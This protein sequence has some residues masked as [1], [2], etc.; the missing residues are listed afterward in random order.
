MN[1]IVSIII[2]G[3]LFVG[4]LSGC[5]NQKAISLVNTLVFD[6]GDFQSIRLDYDMEDI[7]VVEGESGKVTLKEYMN[8]DKK[9]YYAKT[10]NL[11]GEL[12]I[13]EGKRPRRSGFEAYIELYIPPDYNGSLSLHSTSGTVESQ[14]SL[15]LS[16]EICV[17]TTSGIINVSDIKAASV[18]VTTTSGTVDGKELITPTLKIVSTNG[19]LSFARV[20]SDLI[21]IET[22]N[23]NT[24]ISNAS[25]TVKYQSKGGRL[26]MADMKGSGS[27]NA[28]GE[29]TIEVTFSDVTGDISAY[30]KNG[31]ITVILPAVLDFKFSATTKEGSI[32]T[33]FDDQLLI[34]DYISAGSIGLSP[35]VSIGLETRNGDISVSR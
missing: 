28:S 14:I 21:Q 11:N 2:T 16:G 4:V 18:S 19:N 35:E 27:Y 13:T 32:K 24:T 10:A 34:T 29:G 6:M 5:G 7:R 30:T 12:F 22:T 17:D 3:T 26:T 8:V 9:S 31:N 20:E 15:N 23:A 25:G 1:R 33:S